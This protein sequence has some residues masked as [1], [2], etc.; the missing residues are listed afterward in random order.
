MPTQVTAIQYCPCP[1]VIKGLQ[2]F[3]G[4]INFYHRFVPATAQLLHPLYNALVSRTSPVKWS[5][6][7]DKV[8]H[9]AK[10]VLASTTLLVHP[11]QDAP[12]AVTVDASDLAV[13]GI[14]E[15]FTDGLWW[16]LAFFYHKLQ[17][18]QTSY[19]ALD[20]ELLAAYA[21]I[22]HFR[23]FLEGRQFSLST[24]HKPLTFTLNKISAA[25]SARQQRQLS[26]ISEH[27]TWISGMLQARK[28][29]LQM[30]FPRLPFPPSMAS[31]ISLPLGLPNSQIQSTWLNDGQQ[32]WDFNLRTFL[33]DSITHL[34]YV[35]CLLVS[36]IPSYHSPSATVFS[37]FFMASATWAYKQPV[38]L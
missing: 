34:Y 31:L 28:T 36:H 26:V 12:T 16:P 10:T 5:T 7:T 8:F 27:N 14:L 25:W 21:S 6:P 19:S 4:A 29:W 11:P 22:Q 9:D 17:P 23:Y 37:I 35:I 32:L 1:R 3:L 15:Q 38:N 30:L 24:N 18:A 13:E 2:A 33:L 20:R